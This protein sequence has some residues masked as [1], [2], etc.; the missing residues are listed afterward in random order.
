MKLKKL[1][2]T[3]RWWNDCKFRLHWHKLERVNPII[4]IKRKR[5]FSVSSI[6]YIDKSDRTSHWVGHSKLK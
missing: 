3:N 4:Q 6:F 2:G 1:Y 5:P